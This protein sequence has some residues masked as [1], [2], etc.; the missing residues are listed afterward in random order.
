MN[1]LF[2]NEMF[3]FSLKSVQTVL[4][5]IAILS[6]VSILTREISPLGSKFQEAHCLNELPHDKTMLSA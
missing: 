2:F 3:H 6:R 5:S 1:S 4:T